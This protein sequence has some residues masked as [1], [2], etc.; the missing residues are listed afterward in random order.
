[1]FVRVLGKTGQPLED[2]D[3]DGSISIEPVASAFALCQFDLI[4]QHD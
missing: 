2:P 3:G 1:M 4:A